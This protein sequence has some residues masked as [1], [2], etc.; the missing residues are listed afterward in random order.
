MA[1]L[2]ISQAPSHSK[3]P[4]A[5]MSVQL[6]GMGDGVP[7]VGMV[8]GVA[9]ATGGNVGV[10]VAARVGVAVGPGVDR[11]MVSATSSTNIQVR[12]PAPSLYTEKVR[13]MVRPRWPLTS[14]VMER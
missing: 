6:G 10:G 8:V 4:L 11:Q 1:V 3:P 7:G 14:T 2:P 12:P 5:M 13:S 9:V